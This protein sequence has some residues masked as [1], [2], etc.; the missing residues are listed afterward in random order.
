MEYTRRKLLKAIAAM[1]IS[2]GFPLGCRQR[3]NKVVVAFADVSLSVKSYEP[4]LA[5]WQKICS[6]LQ[7]GDRLLLAPISGSTYSEFKPL[8]DEEVQG[9]SWWQWLGEERQ[10]HGTAKQTQT[11]ELTSA[12]KT[13]TEMERSDKT[14]ILDA[15]VLASKIFGG[16]PRK[17][18]LVVC[19]DG[20]QDSANLSF[21][22]T[23]LTPEFTDSFVE[24]TKQAGRLPDLK[25]VHIYFA[26]T[27]AAEVKSRVVNS[28]FEIESFWRSFLQVCGGEL[29]PQNYGPS[30]LH[31]DS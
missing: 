24:K 28:E 7:P 3:T 27:A 8:L 17:R 21:Y 15:F 30:L 19:S 22:K 29:L 31:F 6:C 5:A 23:H 14:D 4:Y 10:E 2:T 11:Q 26:G 13:L 12:F 1:T 25:G 9:V 18:V 20:I 16:D